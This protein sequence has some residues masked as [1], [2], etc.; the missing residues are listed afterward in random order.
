MK[1]LKQ[2]DNLKLRWP[3]QLNGAFTMIEMLV[4]MAVLG[5]LSAIMIPKYIDTVESLNLL[6]CGDKIIDD[7]KYIYNQAIVE[8][9]TTWFVA[10]T[11][12]NSYGIYE[13]PTALSRS[14]ILDPSTNDTSLVDIDVTFPGVTI[15]D[16][17]FGSSLECM[18]D[19][20]GTPSSGGYIVLNVTDTVFVEAET[21][22][23]HD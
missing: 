3:A 15:T 1:S 10:D 17:N 7:L 23:I 19:W 5:I 16:V 9:D 4:V 11:A 6:N 8:H 18:F 22:Y 13:G 20:W 12:A 2:K 14:L 21:G